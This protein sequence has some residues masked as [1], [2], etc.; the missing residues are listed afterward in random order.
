MHSQ[1][2]ENKQRERTASKVSRK[3]DEE[4]E[5]VDPGQEEIQENGGGSREESP[6]VGYWGG[7]VMKRERPVRYPGRQMRRVRGWIQVR[8]ISRRMG[9]DPGRR[10]LR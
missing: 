3:T 6:Q 8:R 4:S 5:G 2:Q 1:E 10:V 7:G 9:V